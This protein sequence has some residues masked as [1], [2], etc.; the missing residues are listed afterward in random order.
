MKLLKLIHWIISLIPF[1]W[2]VTF[3][4]QVLIGIIHF[5][6]IPR[7]YVQTDPYS[8]GL[9]GLNYFSIILLMLS[10]LAVPAWFIISILILVINKKSFPKI[11]SLLFAIGVAGYFLF[12]FE[13]PDV[14]G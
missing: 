9:L 5:K 8:I 6:T 14:F 12:A 13:F 4:I 10:F 2:F 7:E 1:I 11:S 3:L